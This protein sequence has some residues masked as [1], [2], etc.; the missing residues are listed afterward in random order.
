M[1][2]DTRKLTITRCPT[3]GVWLKRFTRG[4]HKH[5]GDVTRPDKALLLEILHEIIRLINEEWENNIL[6]WN[7]LALKATFYL[8]AFCC[9]L[10]D[11]EVPLVDI[12]GMLKHWEEGGLHSRPHVVVCL[13][14]WFKGET[15]IGYHILPVLAVTPSNL[16]PRKWIG[17]ALQTFS[18][19]GIRHRP[20]FRDRMGQRIKAGY[21]EV[22][23]FEWLE[24]V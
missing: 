17:L 1:A 14:G 23:F 7:N 11:E 13:L 4:M 8:L 22:K 2:K 15:G 18:N 24:Q 9:A 16:E 3:Y 5:M 6:T 12:N 10:H 20:I 21:L 19:V